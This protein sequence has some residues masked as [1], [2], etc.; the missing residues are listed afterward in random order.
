[1][2]NFNPLTYAWALCVPEILVE[3]FDRSLAFYQFLGFT[4]V[5]QRPHFAYLEYQNAQF[6]IAQRDNWWETG[7]MEKPYGRGVNFQFST[8]ELDALIG[9]LN[10]AGI[11]LYEA[12]QEKWRDLG[13]HRGGSVEFLVQDPDGY[14]LRFLQKIA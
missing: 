10:H 13:G 2:T 5:Y 11:A 9:K 1:M 8:T 14:L 7:V 3:D 6:M 12:K 4:D